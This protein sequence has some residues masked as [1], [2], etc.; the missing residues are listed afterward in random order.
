MANKNVSPLFRC[1]LMGWHVTLSYNHDKWHRNIEYGSL[2]CNKGMALV[3]QMRLNKFTVHG[4]SV[5]RLCPECFDFCDVIY[6]K[7]LQYAKSN[8]PNSLPSETSAPAGSP[9]EGDTA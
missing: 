6:I 2:S 5:N 4:I 1:F 8:A 9:D 7:A 3:S